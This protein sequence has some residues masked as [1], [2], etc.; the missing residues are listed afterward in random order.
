MNNLRSF[1]FYPIHT[2]NP[3][4]QELFEYKISETEGSIH[5]DGHFYVQ[6]EELPFRSFFNT[7][8]REKE[9]FKVEG[10]SCSYRLLE[11][12]WYEVD[13]YD[14]EKIVNTSSYDEVEEED[15][16]KMRICY[17][18]SHEQKIKFRI[19]NKFNTSGEFVDRLR[20]YTSEDK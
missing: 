19:I 4:I 7:F 14:V 5:F 20:N 15:G 13:I 18:P 11:E 17:F 1:D 3:Y 9:P 12:E 6:T 10:N 2:R 16:S 8:V